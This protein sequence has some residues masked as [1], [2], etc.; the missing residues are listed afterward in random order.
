M[1]Q[2]QLAHH[3]R[4]GSGQDA[5]DHPVE[6]RCPRRS[7]LRGAHG[8]REPGREDRRGGS[9]SGGAREEQRRRAPGKTVGEHQEEQRR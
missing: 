3:Q 6:A 8:G 2:P 1:H 7:A 9:S 5:D 4:E